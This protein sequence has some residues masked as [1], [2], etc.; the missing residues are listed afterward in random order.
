MN[1][2][3][4]YLRVSTTKQFQSGLGLEAQREAV[5]SFAA[6]RGR[7]I[8]AEYV[9]AESGKRDDRPALAEAIAHAKRAGAT[10]LIARLDRLSRS[11]ALIS[12]L[13]EAGVEFQAADMPEAN[14]FVVHIMSAVA[15][16]EREQISARTKAALA[17]AKVR[18]V[19]LGT[20]GAVLAAT[21]KA[22][23]LEY[24]ERL[25]PILAGIVGPGVTLQATADCLTRQNVATREGGQWTP[26]SVRNTLL[27]LGLYGNPNHCQMSQ[28]ADLP[29][30]A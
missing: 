6:T 4:S 10:L 24:A 5:T 19:K 18:G 21:R 12:R 23:A 8:L 25:R 26:T 13:M 7:T 29:K 16:W 11:V 28:Q 22:E 9:E 27:R 14:R 3:I 30:V 17:A 15:E 1:P 2:I 20:H